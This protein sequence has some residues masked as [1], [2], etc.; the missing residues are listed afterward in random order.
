MAEQALSRLFDNVEGYESKSDQQNV[1]E[2][3]IEADEARAL[4]NA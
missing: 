1:A 3:G 2:P 4:K